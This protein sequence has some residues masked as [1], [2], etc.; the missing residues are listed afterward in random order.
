MTFQG[1][2]AMVTGAGSGI[3]RATAC[4][5][6]ARGAAVAAVDIDGATARETARMITA[7]GGRGAG[8]EADVSKAA[9]IDAAMA[10]AVRDLG[11]LRI[12]VNN[13]GILDGYFDVDELEEATWRRVL[14]FDLTG[15]FLG[16]KRALREMLPAGQ[17]RI[18]NMA[19][20]AGL[21]GTGGG[22]A[23]IAAKHGV[24]GLTRQMAVVYAA[25]GIRVNCVCPGAIP[26]GLRAHS[27]TLLGPGIPDISARGVA[28]SD[29]Q[30]RALV[31]AGE[32]GTVEDIAG[33][34]CWLVSDEAR[35]VNGHALVV[36]GGW[37]AK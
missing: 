30:V 27:Q 25:R 29:A 3:G 18:V 32:R 9:E 23:Y 35:Y 16:C 37:R 36:D 31:P 13:A 21:N 17:G 33:A 11:P 24:V 12:M 22:A 20:V 26:T 1:Q 10:S 28:V 19:S 7:A 4:L 8:Y 14:D 6:A 5:L 34:V 15:A 2:M